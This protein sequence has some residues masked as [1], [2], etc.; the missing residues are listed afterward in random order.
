[1]NRAVRLLDHAGEDSRLVLG[2]HPLGALA[3][4]GE[5]CV[6]RSPAPP[7]LLRVLDPGLERKTG[8]DV[9]LVAV[10]EMA[11]V[12]EDEGA[13]TVG[14]RGREVAGE[15]AAPRVAHHRGSLDAQPTERVDEQRN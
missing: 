9:R 1:V 4:L 5:E 7:P 13:H 11:A 8:V 15:D 6:A 10:V 2:R 14:L 12:Q 3:Q